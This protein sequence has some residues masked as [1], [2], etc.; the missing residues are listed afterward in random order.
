MSSKGKLRKPGSIARV[1]S[2]GGRGA[3]PEAPA[4]PDEGAVML[5]PIGKQPRAESFEFALAVLFL[6]RT[7]CWPRAATACGVYGGRLAAQGFADVVWDGGTADLA[8]R[9]ESLVEKAVAVGRLCDTTPG[10][11]ELLELLARA[12]A[13]AQQG[14]WKTAMQA[15]C[16]PR[17]PCRHRACAC[18][19]VLRG[20]AQALILSED[21]V[22]PL[23]AP[24]EEESRARARRKANEP[25]EKPWTQKQKS[26]KKVPARRNPPCGSRSGP[27]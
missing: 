22:A 13:N 3:T 27:P 5:P 2:P 17:P 12:S 4:L 8:M 14:E 21:A 16:P 24:K 15:P 9:V 23:V 19:G 1:R 6:P 20:A 11:A 26:A 7:P 10:A 25:E 18:A